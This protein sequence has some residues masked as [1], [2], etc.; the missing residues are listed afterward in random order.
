MT[1]FKTANG[2]IAGPT[3]LP[4]VDYEPSVAAY[5]LP[6]FVEKAGPN[7]PARTRN[8]QTAPAAASA[9]SCIN[10]QKGGPETPVS[11]T[12]IRL[13]SFTDGQPEI[14][15]INQRPIQESGSILWREPRHG[16][17]TVG[18]W[19]VDKL[20]GATA[21]FSRGSMQEFGPGRR[22]CSHQTTGR[23]CTRCLGD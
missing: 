15:Q 14:F 12:S 2:V 4:Y 16:G 21:G 9:A 22:T 10:Q 19:Q 13:K 11:P 18:W 1:S 8:H 3:Y 20:V 6:R 17:F 7:H 23:C 5:G